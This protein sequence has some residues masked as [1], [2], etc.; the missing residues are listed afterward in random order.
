MLPGLAFRVLINILEC[1]QHEE[2][3]EKAAEDMK[4]QENIIFSSQGMMCYLNLGSTLLPDKIPSRGIEVSILLMRNCEQVPY[5]PMVKKNVFVHSYAS[6][7]LIS[8]RS[9]HG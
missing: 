1:W 7:M 4:K 8:L 9:E 2:Y 5:S 6:S 3:E